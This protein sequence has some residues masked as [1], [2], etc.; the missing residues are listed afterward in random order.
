LQQYK[1]VTLALEYRIFYPLQDA[2]MPF[3][4]IYHLKVFRISLLS[5]KSN[6]KSTFGI[7]YK[8][9]KKMC[10][11]PY[12]LID[13]YE[14]SCYQNGNKQ[15]HV[16]SI[17]VSLYHLFWYFLFIFKNKETLSPMINIGL[18]KSKSFWHRKR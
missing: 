13:D 2:S 1:V 6:L 16:K 15:G 9:L 4:T 7:F 5:V 3:K 8:V 11:Y 10:L 18:S 17:G 14:I 12:Q